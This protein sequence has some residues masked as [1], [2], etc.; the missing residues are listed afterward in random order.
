M[1]RLE[2]TVLLL[3]STFTIAVKRQELRLIHTSLPG[4]LQRAADT[5]HWCSASGGTQAAVLH[6]GRAQLLLEGRS[7]H[8]SGCLFGS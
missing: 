6:P 3:H 4:T 1:H 8:E 2:L 5:S 7:P